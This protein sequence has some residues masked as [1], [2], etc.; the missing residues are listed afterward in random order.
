MGTLPEDACA[1]LA[2]EAHGPDQVLVIGDGPVDQVKPLPI[3]GGGPVGA[4]KLIERNLGI[5]P[6]NALPQGLP[7]FGI[8]SDPFEIGGKEIGLKR[9]PKKPIAPNG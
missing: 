6:L 3:Q 4:G 2:I 7:F 1:R 9:W 8:Y 5:L